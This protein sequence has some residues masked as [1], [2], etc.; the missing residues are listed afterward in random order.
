M[1]LMLKLPVNYLR[2]MIAEKN[3]DTLLI[4]NHAQF[5]SVAIDPQYTSTIYTAP[6]GIIKSRDGEYTW[7]GI[8]NGLFLDFETHVGPLVID[9]FDP[10]EIYTGSV[11]FYCGD[12]YKTTDAGE[13]WLMI[14]KRIDNITSIALDP[15]DSNTLY[16]AT[17]SPLIWKSTD[18]GVHFEKTGMPR[19]GYIHDICINPVN[20][21]E[22]FA[23]LSFKGILKSEDG[24]KNWQSTNDDLPDSNSVF[25]IV[26]HKGSGD[27][28]IVANSG[29]NGRIFWRQHLT[30]SWQGIGLTASEYPTTILI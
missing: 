1:I 20:T 12:L 10:H 13:S 6:W 26:Y 2:V 21:R 17:T 25:K 4:L 19:I 3:W 23:G 8:E 15:E 22:I 27:I 14:Q 9:P 7:Q 30:N 28:S 11:G 18:S 29:D 5:Q 16:V 24:G